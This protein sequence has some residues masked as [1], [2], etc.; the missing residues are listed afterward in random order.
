MQLA[1]NEHIVKEWNYADVKHGMI[2]LNQNHV[3]LTVTNKRIVHETKDKLKIERDEIMIKDVKSVSTLHAK[4]G[5]PIGALILAILGLVVFI[6]GIAIEDGDLF[7]PIGVIGLAL[8]A[9]MIVV[10]VIA[11]TKGAFGLLIRTRGAEGSQLSAGAIATGF[12]GQKKS[13]RI[14]VKVKNDI[15][16]EIVDCL[17]AIIIDG[18]D[19]TLTVENFEAA[20][21]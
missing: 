21:V 14:K 8:M 1:K 3:K 6:L 2:D 19:E 17:G 18:Q 4:Q 7:M 20:N 12:T 11:L 15:A 16:L 13:Q 9:I 5:L 10:I